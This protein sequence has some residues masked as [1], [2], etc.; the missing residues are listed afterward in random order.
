MKMH[1]LKQDIV[2]IPDIQMYKRRRHCEAKNKQQRTDD[3]LPSDDATVQIV[4]LN[5]FP[6]AAGVVIL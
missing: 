5:E 4:E 2:C 1:R 6:K 3:S